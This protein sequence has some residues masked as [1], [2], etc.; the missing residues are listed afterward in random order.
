[1]RCNSLHFEIIL[2]DKII[3]M[4]KNIVLLTLS[5]N[6]TLRD[7]VLQLFAVAIAGGHRGKQNILKSCYLLV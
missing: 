6:D 1:M 7:M 3:S 2:H 5:R 4:F